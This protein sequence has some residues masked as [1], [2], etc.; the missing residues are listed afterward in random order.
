MCARMTLTR[1]EPDEL[2]EELAAELDDEA[3]AAYRPRYNVAPSDLHLVLRAI[4]GRSRLMLARW[5]LP[6]GVAGRAPLVNARAESAPFKD[7]FRAAYVGGRCVVPADGFYEW[8]SLDGT[9]QPIWFH[10]P[11][12]KL[13]LL[14]GLWQDARFT[15]LTTA[16]NA[17]VASV[18]DRMPAILSPA[19]AAAWLQAPSQ[20]LLHPAPDGS[21][22]ARPVSNRVNSP[23]H[24][25][26]DCLVPAAPAA[27]Q[28]SLL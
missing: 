27:R 19:E 12:G 1:R 7:A 22:E 5:G 25:D 2:A 8:K 20:R 11:D 16:P 13:L 14:A 6:S 26:P 4:E 24:D 15:V 9:R 18:H 23:R 28:L 21:L 10:R 3:R 17:D